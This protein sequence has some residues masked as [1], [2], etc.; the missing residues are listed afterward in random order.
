MVRVHIAL[1]LSLLALLLSPK[2]SF[3]VETALTVTRLSETAVLFP[4]QNADSA[5]GNSIQNRTGDVFLAVK[6]PS[7]GA[8]S[9]TVTIVAQ[10]TTNTV[11]GWGPLTKANLAVALTV[12]Q[13]KLVGPF[14][15]RAWNNSAGNMIVTY[16]GAGAADVDIAALRAI[17]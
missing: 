7:G 5:N 2:K 17:P 3:A 4:Y 15:A 1:L 16:S 9:A 12:G 11:P 6:V 10:N 13:E 14:P 8:G